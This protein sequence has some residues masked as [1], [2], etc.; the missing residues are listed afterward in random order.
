MDILNSLE[1][2]LRMAR[3]PSK[4][5]KPEMLVRRIIHGMG[6]RYRLHVT[7]LRGKPDIVFPRWKKV[8]FVHGCFWHQH[9]SRECRLARMP[10]SNLDY[11]CEKL[12][13][14]FF[15]DRV[16]RHKLKSLGWEVL[17]IWECELR[18]HDNIKASVRSFLDL[19]NKIGT[20]EYI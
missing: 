20:R 1:R 14:N 8:I 10:K 11:W 4:N 12:E 16:N 19:E 7:E 5:S 15:R 3:I 2:S 13:K 17:V 18:N 9:K 6:Y